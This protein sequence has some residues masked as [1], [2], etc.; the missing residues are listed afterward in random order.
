MN[1]K[2][3]ILFLCAGIFLISS[4]SCREGG[5]VAKSYNAGINIIPTPRS[6]EKREGSFKLSDGVS[7]GA[8]TPEA[9]KIAT[10]FAAKI[11]LATGYD[12]KVEDKGEI[13]LVLDSCATF[14]P[15]GYALDVESSRVQ[16][17][18]CSPRGLFYGMQSF[19][20]LLPAEIE[21]AGIVRD[22]DWE[23]P[24]ANIIDSPRF[25]YRGIHMDPC[26]HFMTVEE[27]KKQ[28]D[29]LSMFKINTIHWHLTDDQGW[30]IEIKQYPG[31]AEIGGRRIEGEG[32][33]YG[34][35]YYTQ[36]EIKDIVS[37]AAERFITIIPELEIPG[38]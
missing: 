34:P 10:Y 15:E 16:V 36:E 28:I 26:R 6:L 35:F 4:L 20:Q 38:H 19:L 1:I 5:H 8:I 13:T 11:S 18:A 31:L 24:A 27:V 21:S 30:R 3:S 9:K 14:S 23:A 32:V 33:E 25:A 7:I 2:K 29:V 17:T 12:V 22:V 37:Y